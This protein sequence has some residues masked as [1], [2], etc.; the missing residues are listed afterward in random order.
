[1]GKS[2]DVRRSIE[3]DS[4][5]APP[6]HDSTKPGDALSPYQRP[7]AVSFGRVV[8]DKLRRRTRKPPLEVSTLQQHPAHGVVELQPLNVTD[9]NLILHGNSPQATPRRPYG[10]HAAR[11]R[12]A[13]ANTDSTGSWYNRSA[14]TGPIWPQHCPVPGCTYCAPGFSSTSG[15]MYRAYDDAQTHALASREAK[16][17]YDG[18]SSRFSTS[19]TYAPSSSCTA[20]EPTAGHLRPAKYVNGSHE[21]LPLL[22]TPTPFHVPTTLVSTEGSRSPADTFTDSMFI[23]SPWG[24]NATHFMGCESIDNGHHDGEYL[25]TTF[26]DDGDD[27]S[28]ESSFDHAAA[29]YL[30]AFTEPSGLTI[31]PRSMS[32]P[33]LPTFSSQP[34]SLS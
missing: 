26:D 25:R 9:H 23:T 12:S 6:P 3:H 32:A 7:R 1:M 10:P 28:D 34:N 30:A 16:L 5:P 11:S 15:I 27:M 8:L 24:A 13:L 22:S 2:L 17:F 14:V 21:S 20:Y 33:T 31:R 19:S 29:T 4:S 18:G